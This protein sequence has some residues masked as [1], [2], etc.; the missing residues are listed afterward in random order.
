MAHRKGYR[1]RPTQSADAKGDK[2]RIVAHLI[3]RLSSMFEHASAD[4]EEVDR[5]V[6]R[7]EPM[8]DEVL[9]HVERMLASGDTTQQRT[10]ALIAKEL[11]DDRLVEPLRRTLQDARIA[12]E[13][14]L[15]LMTS[16]LQLGHP[17]D[18]ATYLNAVFGPV[19]LM[20]CGR[21]DAPIQVWEL[22]LTQD[23]LSWA[24]SYESRS[25]ASY[26]REH[27][28]P[29]AERG[30]L[31]VLTALLYYQDDDVVLAALNGLER[32]KEPGLLALLEE[33]ARYD[34]AEDV[35][36]AA[37]KA[38][39]RLAART[40]DQP[41]QPWWALPPLPVYVCWLSSIGGDGDQVLLVTRRSPRGNLLT[42]VYTYSDHQGLTECVQL[43]LNE[44]LITVFMEDFLP[45][46]FV[47]VP[48]EVAREEVARAFRATLEAGRRP[49]PAYNLWRAWTEGED[50]R[51]VEI[52]PVPALP[53]REETQLLRLSGDLLLLDEFELWRFP[54]PVVERFMARYTRL[55][56]REQLRP[57]HRLFEMLIDQVVLSS[58][59]EGSA[60]R[61]L[62]PARL[63]RQAWFLMQIYGEE[64]SRLALSALAAAAALERGGA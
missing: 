49:P 55:G 57:G 48:L 8:A 26:V 31:P 58:M 38:V 35:R 24:P 51:R 43:P 61:H 47:E 62:L 32:V 36:R 5:I 28:V 45:L 54:G 56:R 19:A 39:L 12:P 4:P 16:I 37:E 18:Q 60:Y 10:A 33:R 20:G 21:L 25:L 1:G 17:V 63:R 27:L 34:P 53:P 2:A 7:L 42:V 13:V 52:L 22:A 15:S 11:C 23:I 50:P 44:R 59:A 29:R 40:S 6:V 30:M 3:R 14:R 9:A 64:G 46:E 41:P